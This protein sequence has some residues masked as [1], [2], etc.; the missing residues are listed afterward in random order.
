[1][2]AVWF[3]LLHKVNCRERVSFIAVQCKVC[4]VQCVS[5]HCRERVSFI[6]VQCNVCGVFLFTA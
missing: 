3:Y 6:A 1:M 5:I 4:S 2:H